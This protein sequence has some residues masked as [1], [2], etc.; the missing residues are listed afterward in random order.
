VRGRISP[1]QY[2]TLSSELPAKINRLPLREGAHFD[3]QQMLIE[4]DCAVQQA[5]LDGAKAANDAAE[6]NYQITKKL[7]DLRQT[8]TLELEVASAERLKARAKAQELQ[9]IVSKCQILAPFSGRIAE[10]KAREKQFVQQGEPI[11]DIL[12]DTQLEI[13][14]LIPS[15]WLASIKIGDKL[16]VEI[17]ETARA[18]PISI[19]D[20]GAKIDPVSQTIKLS[21]KIEGV[22]SE[23]IAGMSGRIS[24]V[25]P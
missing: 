1:R 22:Y 7:A 17:D 5:Q 14:F 18:Y 16:K 9:A 6:S 21:A 8:G 23:L 13:E 15:C 20:I 12:D 11:I 2:T 4:L 3:N 19:S 24:A 10:I 25:A